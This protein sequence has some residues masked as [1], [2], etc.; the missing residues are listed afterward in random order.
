[1]GAARVA[2][3]LF[4]SSI[5]FSAR[6]LNQSL[7]GCR[8][9]H[10][11]SVDRIRYCPASLFH[12]GSPYTCRVAVSSSGPPCREPGFSLLSDWSSPRTQGSVSPSCC[13]QCGTSVGVASL[14]SLRPLSISNLFAFAVA[15]I[16]RSTGGSL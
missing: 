8:V 14:Y 1:M 10:V 6:V 4:S 9:L 3:W 7:L 15:R 13:I 12:S 11:T 16:A 5:C 2:D